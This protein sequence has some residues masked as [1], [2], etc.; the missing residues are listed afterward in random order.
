MDVPWRAVLVATIKAVVIGSGIAVEESNVTE[1]ENSS[2]EVT[3]LVYRLVVLQPY[4][5]CEKGI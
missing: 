1:S 5:I 2:W 3:L 4:I